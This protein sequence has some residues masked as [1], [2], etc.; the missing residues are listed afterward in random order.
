M[1]QD[2]ALFLLGADVQK[3]HPGL[4]D[5]PDLLGVKAAQKRELQQVFR[6]ALGVGTAVAQGDVA[7][8]NG[9]AGSQRRPADA[10]DALDQQCGPR[11]QG[12]GGAGGDKGVSR[13]VFQQI[14]SHGQRGVLFDFKGKGGVVSDLHHL[15]G[16]SDLHARGQRL[17]AAGLHGPQHLRRPAHQQ[18]VHAVFPAGVQSA[19]DDSPG[20]IVAAHGIHDDLH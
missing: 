6:C 15:R 11:Q 10:L 12:A 3:T 9:D 14:Q 18:N 19:L 2:I 17:F 8:Q 20:S 16:V 4:L 1:A 5:A 13:P 7:A